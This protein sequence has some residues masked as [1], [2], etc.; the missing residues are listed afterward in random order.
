VSGNEKSGMAMS[1]DGVDDWINIPDNDVLDLDQITIFVK[2]N[3]LR[4]S[5]SAEILSKTP[6]I[7]EPYRLYIS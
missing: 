4:V 5:V 7:Y 1:F 3:V 2:V 6:Q